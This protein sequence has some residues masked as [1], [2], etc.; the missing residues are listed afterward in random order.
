MGYRALYYA[1][2]DSGATHLI[3]RQSE[4]LTGKHLK[5]ITPRHSSI[6]VT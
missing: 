4:A 5:Q 6:R 3:H 1:L 2:S